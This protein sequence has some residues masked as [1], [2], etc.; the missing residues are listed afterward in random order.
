M[1]LAKGLQLLLGGGA[2]VLGGACD[3]ARY[4]VDGI[5]ASSVRRRHDV[6]LAPKGLEDEA[7]PPPLR[8]SLNEKAAE[9]IFRVLR[10][11]SFEK[12]ECSCST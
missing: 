7:H 4:R 5:S 12:T 2:L 10:P 1:R 3:S 8:P 9:H 6:S 11:A